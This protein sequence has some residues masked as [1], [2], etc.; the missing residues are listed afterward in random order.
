MTDARNDLASGAGSAG[1]AETP[2]Q[3]RCDSDTGRIE[4]SVEIAASPERVFRAL[5]SEEICSW[6]ARPGV[7][8]T[9][10]W[11][12]DLRAGGR[13]QASGIGNGRP[14]GLEGEFREIDPPR[15]L[16]HTW[17]VAGAPMPPSLV[18]YRLQPFAGGTQ[19]SLEHSG[20]VVPE[21]CVNT[22]AGWETSFR[23]LAELLAENAPAR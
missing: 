6:W 14:Y 22:C 16:V 15:K 2:V 3:A 1:V 7:F 18:T 20:L 13:W 21:A 12:G 9:R 23:R 19:L 8:D 11:S 10:Q 5:A 17:Q 4:A